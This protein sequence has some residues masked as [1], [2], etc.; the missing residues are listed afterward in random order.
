MLHIS[1]R[2]GL[3]K[4]LKKEKKNIYIYVKRGRLQITI[5]YLLYFISYEPIKSKYVASISLFLS[6]PYTYKTL[7]HS[8]YLSLFYTFYSSIS[9]HFNYTLLYYFYCFCFSYS[10][11]LHF[12]FVLYFSIC[13]CRYH[14]VYYV[15]FLIGHDF[16]F[17]ITYFHESFTSFFIIIT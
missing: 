13:R 8:F 5:T 9:F 7:L 15:P 10:F 2:R 11:P 1:C 12:L 14:I 6:L 3:V 17:V 16:F 4:K